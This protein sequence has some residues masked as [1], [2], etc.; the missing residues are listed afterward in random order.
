MS[1]SGVVD[2]FFAQGSTHKV[3]EDYAINSSQGKQDERMPA[4][5]AVSDGC[6]SSP[7]TDMGARLLCFQTW[8]HMRQKG[9]P[10]LHSI[11]KDARLKHRSLTKIGDPY[12]DLMGVGTSQNAFDAT[13]LVAWRCLEGVTVKA[14]GDGVV[15]GRRRDGSL[16]VFVISFHGNAPAYVTYLSEWSRAEMYLAQ[17]YGART[18]RKFNLEGLQVR[19]LGSE[20][21]VPSIVDYEPQNWVHTFRFPYMAYDLV[22]VLSDGVESFVDASEPNRR[23][24]VP[25]QEVLH[26]IFSLRA[27]KG[28]FVERRLKRFLSKT[29]KKRSWEH[30]DDLAV[31]MLYM[32]ELTSSEKIQG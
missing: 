5:V 17:G 19:D 13:L 21:T 16:D 26:E 11:Y 3:C 22:A 12:Q 7:F 14:S 10:S 30:E 8:E 15:V 2:T 4:M 28:S 24:P 23:S 25:I 32:G 31:G 20:V 27:L 29:C 1:N 6:S 18:V 9:E